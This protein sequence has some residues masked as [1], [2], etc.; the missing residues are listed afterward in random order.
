MDEPEIVKILRMEEHLYRQTAA[1][2]STHQSSQMMK[3]PT[4]PPSA[5]TMIK[6]PNKTKKIPAIEGFDSVDSVYQTVFENSAVAITVVDK[7][8][9]IVFW[10]SYAERLLGMKKKDLYLQHV[11]SLYP[12]EEWKKIRS[13][14]IREKGM[15]PHLETTILRKKKEPLN[16]DI[17]LS[18]LKDEHGKI[19]G[20]IAVIRDICEQKQD[21]P[22]FDSL[23]EHADDSI[24]LLDKNFRYIMANNALLSRFNLSR[25][26]VIGKTFGQLH[27]EKETKEFIR[28][29]QR[30]FETGKHVKTEHYKKGK[31][32][33]RTLSP[34]KDNITDET[35]AVAVISKDITDL[36]EAE[37][38][39]KNSEQRYRTIF[40]SSAV[41][42]TVTDKDENIISWNSYAEHLFNM[43]R[44]DLYQKPVKSLYP[45]AEW[46]KIRSEK[47]RKK[48]I[49]H[50]METKILR[51]DGEPLD[52]D[53]SLSVLR[54]YEGKIIG[55][56]GV[57]KDISERKQVEKERRWKIKEL[58]A[59]NK[60][61]NMMNKELHETQQKLKELNEGLE[62]KVEER[63]AEIQHLLKL[64]DEFIGQLGHDI[65]TPLLILTNVL[66][67]IKEDIK[68]EDVKEDCDMAI[69]NV[70]YIENLVNETLQIAQLSSP[71]MK[72]NVTETNLL[73]LVNNVVQDNQL[74]FKQQDIKI[75]NLI[76]ENIIVKADE[77]KIN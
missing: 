36:M 38:R 31:W 52:V 37:Q 11:S 3:S 54:D 10:N 49:K 72:L 14:K 21:E 18:V 60:L 28:K 12:K 22:R 41:A 7:N 70:T 59:M 68:E 5:S 62:K 1:S 64:K 16:V 32:F 26:K 53:V 45:P 51:K 74:V 77:L 25:E 40:D 4:K 17:S 27:S 19:Q 76:D 58:D 47:I 48:G 67:M 44:D 43:T 42:I 15:Q 30:V 33:L 35:I 55:S 73:E 34:V 46:E 23:M 6:Q 71:D 61:L 8:E 66:P 29:A 69:R 57:I 63:T 20:S 75:E 39:L 2:A 50:Q 24:Y 56:I 65:K 9:H 13:L